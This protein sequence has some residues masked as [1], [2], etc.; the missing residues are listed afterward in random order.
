MMYWNGMG[1]GGWIMMTVTVVA[2]WV[3][4][5]AV[6]V[7]LVRSVNRDSVRRPP[8]D[9]LELLD[10]RFA[11]GEIDEADYNHRRELLTGHSIQ[12]R[13]DR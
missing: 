13:V 9:A 2:F 8:K 3:L 10:E 1:W 12:R 4:V 6:V 5:V 11:R 7:A